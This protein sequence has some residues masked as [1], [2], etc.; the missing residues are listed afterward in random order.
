MAKESILGALHWSTIL[1]WFPS[2]SHQSTP[3]M[4]AIHLCAAANLMSSVE[5]TWVDALREKAGMK[6]QPSQQTKLLNLLDKEN[7]LYLM[8]FADESLIVKS[9]HTL[10]SEG[11]KAKHL[12]PFTSSMMDVAKVEVAKGRAKGK[13]EVAKGRAKGKGEVE[14]AKDRAKGKGR[15]KT[16]VAE[17]EGGNGKTGENLPWM[18]DEEPP[19]PPP[20]PIRLVPK[21]ASKSSRPRS[22]KL[23]R[24]KLEEAKLE[25]G[26]DSGKREKKKDK[27]D[28][29]K[30]MSEE[31]PTKV[32]KGE[33]QPKQVEMEDGRREVEPKQVKME[34]RKREVEPKQVMEDRKREVEPKQVEMEDRKR[35]AQSRSEDG[36]DK[37]PKE[38]SESS[39]EIPPT[40]KADDGEDEDDESTTDD[41]P[42][43][44]RTWHLS[45]FVITCRG[46]E[47][48]VAGDNFQEH[49][50]EWISN[51]LDADQMQK[52][53]KKRKIG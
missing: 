13:G 51:L 5:K 6:G 48:V 8:R 3:V 27:N 11:W 10:E 47:H 33:V 9:Y 20:P 26:E 4:R 49:V 34:D 7:P 36:K 46:E 30:T 17:A 44:G 22:P 31:E 14:V 28:T 32:G 16:E 19:Y 45:V 35:E 1:G 52:V 43:F 38:E 29:K 24:R 41:E 37:Q 2:L 25:E 39:G 12:Q 40:E 18:G 50:V 42:D 23:D 53:L 21:S 15:V